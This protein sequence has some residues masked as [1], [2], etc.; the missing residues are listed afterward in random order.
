MLDRPGKR[1]YMRQYE[2]VRMADKPFLEVRE[3]PEDMRDT[4][5]GIWQSQNYLVTAWPVSHPE[6]A[7]RLTVNRRQLEADGSWKQGIVWD[8]LQ[9]IK[10]DCGYGGYTAVE[11]YPA[12]NDIMNV[13]NMRHL[14][15]LKA[16]LGYGLTK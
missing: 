6:V 3:V 12:D 16:P 1:Q 15:V 2:K 5:L 9:T 4:V 8:E 7:C 14:W 10:H 13:A 11:V